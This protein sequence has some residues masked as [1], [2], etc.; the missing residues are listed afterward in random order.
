MK[1]KREV[2]GKITVLTVTEKYTSQDLAILKAGVTKLALA[3]TD[4]LMI[5]DMSGATPSTPSLAAE[6]NSLPQVAAEFEVALLI[7]GPGHAELGGATLE[8]ARKKLISSEFR[9]SLEETFLNARVNQLERRKSELGDLEKRSSSIEKE[10]QDLRSKNTQLQDV[11][12][13]ALRQVRGLLAD[14]EMLLEVSAG[15]QPISATQDEWK[16]TQE[17]IKPILDQ[18]GISK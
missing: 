8:N 2:Q 3:G 9:A 5:I 14:L 1:I 15:N 6:I 4:K 13:H 10:L 18:L 7:A 11:H 16:R 17:I 12:R